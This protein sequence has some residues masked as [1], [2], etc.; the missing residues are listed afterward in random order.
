MEHI[1]KKPTF[2]DVCNHMIVGTVTTPLS[3]FMTI[4][5]TQIKQSLIKY[6]DKTIGESTEKAPAHHV[7]NVAITALR[8]N[9]FIMRPLLGD[10]LRL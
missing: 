7:I 9:L 6:D 10:L 1:F 3:L 4:R 8:N 5:K 2:C